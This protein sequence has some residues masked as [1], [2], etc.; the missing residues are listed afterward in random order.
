VHVLCSQHSRTCTL[1]DGTA[2]CSVSSTECLEPS[3]LQAVAASGI[4]L[5]TISLIGPSEVE[6][7]QGSPYGAC[8]DSTPMSLQ[9][10]R[11]AKAHS[12]S[13]G[14]LT[15]TVMACKDGFAFRQHGLRGCAVDTSVVGSHIIT[16]FLMHGRSRI[17]VNRTL[18]VLERCHGARSMLAQRGSFAFHFPGMCLCPWHVS[19]SVAL[20]SLIS[21]CTEL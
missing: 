21:R 10:D 7:V 20:A 5:P 19:M 11:G 12:P 1:E 13:E 2:Y 3:P 18:W 8:T 9:C 14:D 17:A 6:I 16:F 15:W 4:A